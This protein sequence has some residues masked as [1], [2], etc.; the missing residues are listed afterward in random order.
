MPVAKSSFIY[1]KGWII[2]LKVCNKDRHTDIYV[3]LVMCVL[4]DLYNYGS[5]TYNLLQTE[6]IK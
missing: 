4:F 5:K 6:Y 3:K 1:W 2:A